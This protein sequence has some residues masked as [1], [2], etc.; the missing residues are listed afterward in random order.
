MSG[1]EAMDTSDNYKDGQHPAPVKDTGHHG[2]GRSQPYSN[3]QGQYYPPGRQQGPVYP[4][5]GHPPVSQFC[6]CYSAPPHYHPGGF[7]YQSYPYMQHNVNSSAAGPTPPYPMDYTT[8]Y[9]HTGLHNNT[10][11][12]I[13]TLPNLMHATI[14]YQYDGQIQQTPHGPQTAA[15]QAQSYPHASAQ[16]PYGPGISQIQQGMTNHPS[17]DTVGAPPEQHPNTDPKIPMKLQPSS[18]SR[19]GHS[20]SPA[21]PLGETHLSAADSGTPLMSP[22]NPDPQFAMK[23]QPSSP[24]GLVVGEGSGNDPDSRPGDGIS[25]LMEGFKKLNVNEDDRNM[26][27]DKQKMTVGDSD[28]SKAGKLID[29]EVKEHMKT[30]ERNFLSVSSKTESQQFSQFEGGCQSSGA[31]TRHAAMEYLDKFLLS[32]LKPNIS[33][34]TLM[35]YIEVVSECDVQRIEYTLD[36]TTAVITVDQHP[37]WDSMEKMVRKKKLESETVG[38]QR[39]AHTQSICVH[40]SFNGNQEDLF[41]NYFEN[42]K[43]GNEKWQVT[44]VQIMEDLVVV[45]FESPEA[46]EAVLSQPTHHVSGKTWNVQIFYTDIGYVQ[47]RSMMIDT[48]W[49]SSMMLGEVRLLRVTGFLDTLMTE[50]RHL[51]EASVEG[52]TKVKLKGTEAAIDTAKDKITQLQQ[53]I[54]RAKLDCSAAK[55]K[56]LESEFGARYMVDALSHKGIRSAWGPDAN[57]IYIFAM[58]DRDLQ[59]TVSW[60]KKHIKEQHFTVPA[61]KEDTFAEKFKS[62]QQKLKEHPTGSFSFELSR[63]SRCIIVVAQHEVSYDVFESIISC[64]PKPVAIETM[65]LPFSKCQLRFMQTHMLDKVQQMKSKCR[66]QLNF[67]EEQCQLEIKGEGEMIKKSK[68]MLDEIVLTN[69]ILPLG[70]EESEILLQSGHVQSLQD[71]VERTE[72]CTISHKVIG[73]MHSKD[74]HPIMAASGAT[75]D[76]KEKGCGKDHRYNG[77]QSHAHD[78]EPSTRWYVPIPDLQE[79][80]GTN[81]D[82]WQTVH[83]KSRRAGRRFVTSSRI[84]IKLKKGELAKEK[85]DVIINTV[86]K[87]LSWKAGR[88]SKSIVEAGGTKLQNECE[89]H[90]K[91]IEGRYVATGGG[92]LLCGHVFHCCLPPAQDLTAGQKIEDLIQQ[93]LKYADVLKASSV[94]FPALGTGGLG[95]NPSVV[96]N[97]MYK[98][99]REYEEKNSSSNIQE[100]RFVIFPSNDNVFKVFEDIDKQIKSSNVAQ[101]GRSSNQ[102][103]RFPTLCVAEIAKLKV[104]IIV[105][106]SNCYLNL[107]YGAVSKSLVQ[108]GGDSIQKECDRY[109]SR[110][111]ILVDGCFAV[112]KS[113]NLHCKRIFHCSLPN[114]SSYGKTLMKEMIVKM[115]DSAHRYNNTSIAFPALGTGKLGYPSEEVA[116]IMYDVVAAFWKKNPQTR[117]EDVRFVLYKGDAKTIKA[118]QDEEKTRGSSRLPPVPPRSSKPAHLISNSGGK[119]APARPQAEFDVTPIKVV[120]KL[121]NIAEEKADAVI[122]PINSDMNLH[123]GSVSKALLKVGGHELEQKTKDLGK[124]LQDERIVNVVIVNGVR[125]CHVDRRLVKENQKQAILTCLKY[126][127]KLLDKTVAFPILQTGD[128][129]EEMAD[130][131]HKALSQFLESSQ[132]P[133]IQEVRVVIHDHEFFDKFS[134]MFGQLT[135]DE[136]KKEQHRLYGSHQQ[137]TFTLWSDRRECLRSAKRKL[138]QFC[139]MEE[140]KTCMEIPTTITPKD[141]SMVGK[142]YPKA[143]VCLSKDRN[144]IEMKGKPRM[145]LQAI[146]AFHKLFQRNSDDWQRQANEDVEPNILF[147]PGEHSE[148]FG[149]DLNKLP[150][151]TKETA[152]YMRNMYPNHQLTHPSTNS[153]HKIWEDTTGSANEKTR[154]HQWRAEMYKTGQESNHTKPTQPEGATWNAHL[155][156]HENDH[157]SR[158]EERHDSSATG[159]LKSFI[160]SANKMK[161]FFLDP[162]AEALAAYDEGIS[163]DI[164]QS[165]LHGENTHKLPL[166]EES[167]TQFIVNFKTMEEYPESDQSDKVEILRKEEI[168]TGNVSEKAF[169]K[170]W[171]PMERGVKVVALKQTDAAYKGVEEH[172]TKSC[173]NLDVSIVKVERVQNEE[174]FRRYLAKK[175]RNASFCEEKLWYHCNTTDSINLINKHGVNLNFC[176]NQREPL[177]EGIYFTAFDPITK[178]QTDGSQY[179]YLC[180][181]L[182][183]K[184]AKGVPGLRDPTSQPADDSSFYHS[185]VDDVGKPSTYVVFSDAQVYPEYLVTYKINQE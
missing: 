136:G 37:D 177:G 120:V 59:D 139:T 67:K 131:L 141:I 115:L 116:K 43:S 152:N 133:K 119:S 81:G 142:E 65:Q 126:S 105:N 68:K 128:V 26:A 168:D 33:E 146:D 38:I 121:G 75:G 1:H 123:N 122:N 96:A 106:T 88:L 82:G 89:G 29:N 12:Q 17:T 172:M 118:F 86:G 173:G 39:I 166:D 127:D 8:G 22:A 54:K 9:R 36:Q 110:K 145:V 143:Q 32:G 50:L 137:V 113:G 171:D 170:T 40:G 62:L 117:L 56:Y 108:F 28:A 77:G 103:G 132:N 92:N 124:R 45:T 74:T 19:S 23:L 66:V 184:N 160:Q 51:E 95:Y 185:V 47:E 167:G 129:S 73:D 93:M 183:G 153:E 157:D 178:T 179:A 90:K 174:L 135:K 150:S 83:P 15:E 52:D 5:D 24:A 30:E 125:V 155:E 159:S 53:K 144:M 176:R 104:D 80:K 111:W 78:Q 151:N 180:R 55:K 84:T 114:C 98:S 69:D 4:P 18:P 72:R 71:H 134:K 162:D 109:I 41:R 3:M 138:K 27:T 148:M 57:T 147:H 42:E 107:R 97:A 100:V 25:G 16:P 156:N 163:N 70:S 20:S 35:N 158:P 11:Q 101:P 2:A 94:S 49:I 44:R 64:F 140:M 112:T 91:L 102:S 182:V 34:E 165:Y 85:A 99:V 181:V 76:Y 6:Y 154:T 130:D 58:S 46:V 31:G 149:N 169:P 87:G 7:V 10:T 161:W 175:G 79:D 60:I 164:E 21:I 63:D 13:T 14:P 61:M 48:A